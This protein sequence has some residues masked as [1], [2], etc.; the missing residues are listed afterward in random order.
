MRSEIKINAVA[1][2]KAQQRFFFRESE[3]I[4]LHPRFLIF[5]QLLS[6]LLQT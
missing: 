1:P 5:V 2:I 3:A 4:S 6:S